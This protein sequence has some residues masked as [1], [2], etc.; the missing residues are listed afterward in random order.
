[1][2]SRPSHQTP[3]AYENAPV[4][5]ATGGVTTRVLD[6]LWSRP[7][8]ISLVLSGWKKRIARGIYSPPT[9]PKT[10]FTPLQRRVLTDEYNKLVAASVTKVPIHRFPK[11]A[12]VLPF[13][14]MPLDRQ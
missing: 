1:M 7:I 6:E 2:N 10:H 14:E 5:Y 3:R 8:G 12:R 13:E 9:F 11:S 4:Y